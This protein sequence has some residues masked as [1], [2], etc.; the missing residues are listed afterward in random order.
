MVSMSSLHFFRWA[1]QLKDSGH[2]VYW[3]DILDGG[4]Q[5]ARIDWVRQIV[6]WKR[7]WNYPGRHFIKK[8]YP[9]LSQWIQHRNERNTATVFEKKLLEIQ[10]DVVHSF[11]MQIAC[12][13]ILSVLLKHKKIKW[14]YS[15]WGSDMFYFKNLNISENV[16]KLA[17]ER[18]DFLITDCNRDCKIAKSLG[19]KN[20]FLGIFPGNGGIV[21]PLDKSQLLKPKDRDTILI[22][23]YNDDI[24]RGIE[25]VKSFD[26][27][28]IRLLS[29]F[30]I[31][32]FGSDQETFEYITNNNDLK[33]LN[34]II[35]LKGKP[36][37]NDQLMQI[38][39]KSYLYIANSLSD[40]LPNALLE[41]MGMGCFPIQSNP[42]NVMSEII[43]HGKNGLL[44]ANP[45]NTNEINYLISQALMDDHIV[46]DGFRINV[47]L[48]RERCNREV[49]KEK[50]VN[51]YESAHKE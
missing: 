29:N 11:A 20:K 16:M 5:V 23:A 4:E 33:N 18:I 31:V 37:S 6:G 1:E 22:K 28:L 35:Y 21:Y 48:V 8:K 10:P 49:L 46:E 32:L 45:L 50:I 24:G 51:I 12:I 13:P 40:G 9:T 27:K 42:G 7:K 38:M 47:D 30:Q 2:E 39:N 36:I 44:I 41:A 17:L 43:N 25:I 26:I 15:S 19:F 3:F 34:M 14:I